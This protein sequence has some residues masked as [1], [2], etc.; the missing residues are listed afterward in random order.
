MD[1]RPR[2]ILLALLLFAGA[3][4]L[5]LRTSSFPFIE[6]DD[7]S[8]VRDNP[9]LAFGKGIHYCIGAS[10]ARLE[11]EVALGSFLERFPRVRLAAP[12]AEL[13]WRSGFMIR[14]LSRLPVSWA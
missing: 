13:E 2:T 3:L 10:L 6:Y 14:G 12:L 7:P 8:Y 9:H 4:A 11:G 1:S 5:Y